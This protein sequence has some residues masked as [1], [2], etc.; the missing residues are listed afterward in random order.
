MAK[1]LGRLLAL[2]AVIGAAA[3]AYYYYKSKDG[4]LEDFDDF[5]DFDDDVNDDLEDFLK[6][7][8]ENDAKREYV[9]LNFSKETMEEAKETIKKAGET[10]EDAVSDTVKN[11]VKPETPN[12]KVEEFTFNDLEDGAAGK[13]DTK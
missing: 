3:G 11:V 7:E 13:T 9:P 12:G 8:T 1:K 2:T 5:D 4:A 6:N 10:V